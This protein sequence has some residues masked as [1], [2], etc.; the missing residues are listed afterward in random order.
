MYS[1]KAAQQPDQVS[2]CLP[3]ASTLWKEAALA[4]GL[5]A[6]L[7]SLNPRTVQQLL[8][9]LTERLVLFPTLCPCPVTHSATAATP[10]P[11][12]KHGKNKPIEELHADQM[13]CGPDYPDC[14]YCYAPKPLA[15]AGNTA[16]SQQMPNDIL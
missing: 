4:F 12:N 15:G 2:G 16:S 9:E 5:A 14:W 6:C 11:A 7:L 10:E 8:V 3:A 1:A 13:H